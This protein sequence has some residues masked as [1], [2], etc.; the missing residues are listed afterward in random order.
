M[1]LLLPILFCDLFHKDFSPIILTLQSPSPLYNEEDKILFKHVLK[2]QRWDLWIQEGPKNLTFCI[3]TIY[4]QDPSLLISSFKQA[5]AE[6]NRYAV[7]LDL[8]FRESF[9]SSYSLLSSSLEEVLYLNMNSPSSS[10]SDDFCYVLPLLQG[11]LESHKEYCH[12][13]MTTHKEATIA[14][15]KAFKMVDMRKWIQDEK[16]I[17]YYQRMTTSVDE[18]RNSFL[19]L[20]D[21]IKA[22]EATAT[23]RDHTGLTFEELCP[24]TRCIP[25]LSP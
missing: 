22:K 8:L 7:F 3:H 17:L 23:L 6:R 14:A 15:C 25:L 1:I 9:S 24:L 18:A 16:Y 2:I 11:K 21:S 4:T 5:L 10:M 13:A 12:L 20:K 19:S